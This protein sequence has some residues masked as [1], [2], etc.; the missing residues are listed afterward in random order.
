[1]YVLPFYLPLLFGIPIQPMSLVFF[2]SFIIKS[3]SSLFFFV[4]LDDGRGYFK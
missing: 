3:P 1:M 4:S 2:K